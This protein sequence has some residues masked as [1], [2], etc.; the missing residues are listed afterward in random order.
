[1]PFVRDGDQRERRSRKEQVGEHGNELAEKCAEGPDVVVLLIDQTK[2]QV[3][4]QQ[5]D[6]CRRQ[7]AEEEIV[8]AP[9]LV[10]C[11]HDPY[12]DTVP[13]QADHKNSRVQ[14]ELDYLNRQDFLRYGTVNWA[15]TIQ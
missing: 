15:A 3:Y 6:V 7:V 2:W 11:Y 1:M 12:H 14:H 4:A 9:R 13:A 10:L 8:K 5:R